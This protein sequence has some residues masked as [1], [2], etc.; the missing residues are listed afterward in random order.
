[1]FSINSFRKVIYIFKKVKD[2]KLILEDQYKNHQN[3]NFFI[4]FCVC[5][6]VCHFS[7]NCAS[8]LPSPESS[9]LIVC[10]KWIVLF[11][12]LLWLSQIFPLDISLV[13]PFQCK[14]VNYSVVSSWL[15]RKG[16]G[17][18]CSVV[19]LSL[20][21]LAFKSC[22]EGEEISPLFPKLLANFQ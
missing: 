2:L 1:M 7:C 4:H 9:P 19:K 3:C 22:S 16:T 18:I 10:V 21:S 5:V 12:W 8:S 11:L 6:C 13:T 15:S 17:N 14:V 20:Y